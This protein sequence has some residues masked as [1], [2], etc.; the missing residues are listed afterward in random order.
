MVGMHPAFNGLLPKIP[1]QV[2]SQYGGVTLLSINKAA[3]RVTRSGQD[4]AGLGRWAWTQYRGRNNVSLR[5]ITAYR[6]VRN[7]AGAMSVRSQQRSYFDAKD[8]D[9]CPRELFNLDLAAA[10]RSWLA[11][12]DKIWIVLQE[13][14]GRRVGLELASSITMYKY[15]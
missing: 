3:H 15:F 10:I 5:V 9:R 14:F 13:R 2:R 11:A 4:T 12:G 6:P 1:S 8:E 7:T